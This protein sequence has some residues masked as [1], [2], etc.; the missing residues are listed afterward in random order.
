MTGSTRCLCNKQCSYTWT[1]VNQKPTWKRAC[2]TEYCYW[3]PCEQARKG[4]IGPNAFTSFLFEKDIKMVQE[5][6][7]H[8]QRSFWWMLTTFI[9]SF[10]EANPLNVTP[11][12]EAIITKLVRELNK[13]KAVQVKT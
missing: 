11:F 6:G 9:Q 5:S 4:P 8:M 13:T 7:V 1:V 3:L 2:E 10:A 12:K